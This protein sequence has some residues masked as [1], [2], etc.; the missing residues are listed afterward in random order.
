MRRSQPNLLD[1]QRGLYRR[2]PTGTQYFPETANP[3][4]LIDSPATFSVVDDVFRS[5]RR[6]SLRMTNSSA[7]QIKISTVQSGLSQPHASMNLLFSCM[8]LCERQTTVSAYIHSPSEPYTSV[9]PNT[10]TTSPNVWSPVFSNELVPSTD[11][12]PNASIEITLII[13][14]NTT[15]PVFMTVPNLT[16]ADP[17]F[18]NQFVVLSQR[19]FPDIFR[20]IDAQQINPKRPLM[21]FYHSLTAH[22]S[23]AMD[24]YTRIF[25]YDND[26]L[27]PRQ[28][29]LIDT[30]EQILTRSEMTDP[31]LMSDEYMQWAAMFIGARLLSDVQVAGTSILTDP[32]FNFKRWQITTKAFGFSAG[33]K[34]SIVAAVQTVLSDTKSVLVTP[35]WEGDPWTI[36]IRTLHAETS[37]VTS[38]GDISLE[39]LRMANLAK[40]AGYVLVHETIDE[41]NF[42]L[43]DPNFGVFDQNVLG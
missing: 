15:L 37:G 21:K 34:E 33:N 39:V 41:I 23:L 31:L 19:F 29:L 25:P 10:Q 20:E 43:N 38:V 8:I 14:P 5:S 12:D 11:V 30:P 16:H 17:D 22:A 2:S 4:W 7:G 24:E 6:F 28:S 35:L 13:D 32:N 27:T 40:P 9:E 1:D 36:M 26:E 42:V 18:F 3:Q